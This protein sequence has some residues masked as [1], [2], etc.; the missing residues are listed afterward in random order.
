MLRRITERER[1]GERTSFYAIFENPAPSS[2]EEFE[3]LMWEHMQMLHDHDTAEWDAE[4]SPDPSSEEESEDLMWKHRQMLHDY[5]TAESDPEYSPE[6]ANPHFGYC[7]GG[8][9]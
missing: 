8:L 5:D 7:F 4:Y 6:P 3:D 9:G 2:E 1:V